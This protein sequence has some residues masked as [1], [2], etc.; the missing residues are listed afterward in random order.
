MAI[1]LLN[2]LPAMEAENQLQSTQSALQNTLFQLASGSRL[3]SGADDPAGLAIAN[4]L[5]A[6]IAALTQ[7]S[8]NAASGVGLL[9]VADG[10][11]AQITTLLNRAIT[12][13]TEAST[14]T[15]SD[16]QRATL[17]AE[18]TKIEAEI[19]NIGSAT[20]YNGAPVFT[21]N[22][23]NI[24]LTDAVTS[25]TIGFT[26]NAL[27]AASLGLAPQAGGGSPTPAVA[28]TAD[29][30]VTAL[31]QDGDTVTIGG[32][33]YTFE[34][35]L[36][37]NPTVPNQVLSSLGTAGAA[38]DL[39]AAV[40]LGAFGL[41]SSAGTVPNPLVTAQNPFFNGN[42]QD[43]EMDMS[44]ITPGAAGDNLA[45]SETGSAITVSGPKFTGGA[46]AIPPAPSVTDT[47]STATDAQATLGLIT[48][49]IVNVANQRGALGA[50]INRLNSASNVQ[51][52]Q[53]Q[54]LT[55]A[56]DQITAANIPQQVANLAKFSILAQ[57]GISAL[58]QANLEQQIVLRLLQ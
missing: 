57:T 55:S 16:A 38:I 18:Y 33:T 50:T 12:L 43:V 5:Q 9:Q 47:L 53:V 54:N 52:V 49:A 44:A 21:N 45:L 46:D 14:G 23:V 24:L 27:S 48:A 30:V 39:F 28:A 42:G 3:N 56:E 13:A 25:N 41:L 4:G 26:T 19:D 20:T 32:T 29:L 10:A 51:N 35:T 40:T 15:V 22:P 11:L 17:N 8:Q 2:N 31:P 1:S 37:T 6:N 34:S 58:A 7:S 36:S